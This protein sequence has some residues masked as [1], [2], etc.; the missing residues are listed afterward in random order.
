LCQLSLNF[1]TG[2][3]SEEGIKRIEAYDLA[4]DYLERRYNILLGQ[5]DKGEK[6]ND[7]KDKTKATDKD[8]RF[9]RM[10]AYMQ[11]GGYVE[12]SLVQLVTIAGEKDLTQEELLAKQK[13]DSN[14]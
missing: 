7:F 11:I 10:L 13:Q 5:E 14:K 1:I 3:N 6:L 9:V 8:N 2:F 12:K 4:V